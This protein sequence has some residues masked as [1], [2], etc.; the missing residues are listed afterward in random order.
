MSAY[1]VLASFAEKIS[2]PVSLISSDRFKQTSLYSILSKYQNILVNTNVEYLVGSYE[3]KEIKILV[4]YAQNYPLTFCYNQ[5]PKHKVYERAAVLLKHG[6]PLSCVLSYFQIDQQIDF[7]KVLF[8]SMNSSVLTRVVQNTLSVNE[9]AI[10]H[11]TIQQLLLG[12]VD[13]DYRRQSVIEQLRLWTKDTK[14]RVVGYL[15]TNFLGTVPIRKHTTRI[16]SYSCG[17]SL[18]KEDPVADSFFQEENETNG[19]VQSITSALTHE[20]RQ[21]ENISEKEIEKNFKRYSIVENVQVFDEK[22]KKRRSYREKGVNVSKVLSFSSESK[23][24]NK[25]TNS[26]DSV[27]H[28]EN[29]R[30]CIASDEN[31]LGKF[32]CNVSERKRAS[33]LSIKRNLYLEDGT[34]TSPEKSPKQ[35]L[36]RQT[37]DSTLQD[38]VT[39]F[40]ICQMQ[41]VIRG[42]LTRRVCTFKMISKRK[43]VFNEMAQTEETLYKTMQLLVKYFKRPLETMAYT[44]TEKGGRQDNEKGLEIL[45]IT[46]PTQENVDRIFNPS[47]QSVCENCLIVKDKLNRCLHTFKAESMC[48]NSLLDCFTHVI[49]L[50]QYTIHYN[51]SLK[52]WKQLSTKNP[53]V[54][55]L[56]KTNKMQQE[57]EHQVLEQ[58][59]IQ[60]VQRVM[61][62]PILISEL[63]KT[64]PNKHPDIVVLNKAYRKYHTFSKVVDERA[65]ARDNLYVEFEK[66]NLLEFFTSNRVLFF[67]GDV[68][69][70]EKTSGVVL[71]VNDLILVINV[72]TNKVF[73]T[74]EID[75]QVISSPEKNTVVI[76]N[77]SSC[78]VF[79]ASFITNEYA[80]K[81]SKVIQKIV[82]EKWYVLNNINPLFYISK[83]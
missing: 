79:R 69:L 45:G 22:R 78:A 38:Q 7:L 25:E 73:K 51:Y 1:I 63:I 36:F 74:F 23:N 30:T 12:K 75:D 47:F 43:K 60:P 17:L 19:S 13:D 71:I 21:E 26:D 28:P 31:F 24:E 65:T 59:L 83:Y 72:Q 76:K 16:K 20:A 67:K 33:S 52:V 37:C 27:S 44:S 49:P 9:Q 29:E 54:I 6:V 35:M 77:L 8:V 32:C 57:L 48:G 40:R 34:K 42:F 10:I 50:L 58:L 80:E 56:V 55:E 41:R 15:K 3:F 64:T 46:A 39:Q 18:K 62:Y 82:D 70:G 2:F 66:R 68:D 4:K 11:D 81:C 61:R 53:L 14:G 5:T